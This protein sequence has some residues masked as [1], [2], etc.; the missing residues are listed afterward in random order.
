MERIKNEVHTCFHCG[1]T[2]LLKPIG[3][4]DGRMKILLKTITEMSLAIR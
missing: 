1:N 4:P 2:G 3:K